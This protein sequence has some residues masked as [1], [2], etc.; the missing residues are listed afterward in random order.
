MLQQLLKHSTQEFIQANKNEDLNRLLLNKA[1]FPDVPVQLAVEQIKAINKAKNKL[2]EWHNCS[3][4]IFPPLLSMEQCSSEQTAQFKASKFSG[5]TMLDLT[6]G[7]GIDTYYLSKNFKKGT[8]VEQSEELCEIAKHNFKTLSASNIEVVTN[9]AEN[10]IE[11]TA[12]QYDLIYIDPARRKALKKV[13]KFEDC[14]PDAVALL[15][16]LRARC[17]TLII[18][19]SPMMDISLGLKSLGN[20]TNVVVLA[21]ENEVKEM[22]FVVGEKAANVE[23]V[24]LIGGSSQKFSFDLNEEKNCDVTIGT[25]DKYLYEP[26][27]AILKSGAFKSIAS[28]FN[29]T[30]LGINTHLYTSTEEIK[31]FPGRKFKVNEVLSYDKKVLK[32]RFSKA[33]IAIRNFPE[34]VAQIR[35]KL[36]ISDGGDE[37]LFF[38]SDHENKKKVLVCSKV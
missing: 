17:K 23:T 26:N 37:Y 19:A 22:L 2:P 6:G 27:S 12:D 36:S 10:F 16:E 30:K 31:A 29:I 4:I 21:V 9:S 20:E 33:N 25:V 3:G 34:S 13:F 28:K 8:Y 7:T 38:I 5:N 18:K 14:T 15:P 32:S 11:N 35:K 24:N 1:K